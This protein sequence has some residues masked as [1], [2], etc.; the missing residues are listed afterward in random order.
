MKRVLVWVLVCTLAAALC[1]LMPAAS[2]SSVQ[3]ASLVSQSNAVDGMMRISLSS[4]QSNSYNLTVDGTYTMAGM[5]LSS[6]SR[7]LIELN[8]GTVYATYNGS[9]MSM[10][11]SVSLARQSGGIRIAESS[12]PSNTYPGNLTFMYTGGVPY[13]I[14]TVYMEDYVKG[15]LPYEM[16]NTF[17][18]EALK[19]Q[20]VAARTYAI[21][22][23]KSGGLYDVTDTVNHQVYRGTNSGNGNCIQAVDA[24]KGIV[25]RY[26]GSYVDATYCAS[27]GG[28][29]ELNSNAWGSNLVGYLTMKDDPYDLANPSSITKSYMLYKTPAY[30]TSTTAYSMISAA[31]AAKRGGTA[32]QY[33]INEIVDVSLHSTKFASPSRL[34]TQMRVTVRFNNTVQDSVDIAIFPTVES[35]MGL[36]INSSDNELYTVIK[37]SNGFRISARRYG[38]GVGMSQR[39]A[40]QMANS[41]LTYRHILGFYYTGVQLVEMNFTTNWSV[42]NPSV[43]PLPTLPSGTSTTAKKGRVSLA[44][45]SN[46]LNLRQTP[47]RKSVV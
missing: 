35:A 15:V 13:V 39:G 10:G 19:A 33:A 26:N 42:A 40:Q 44:N 21:R 25:M 43:T 22:N 4:M 37:E 7:V 34:Y 20:A 2:A 23:K 47:D 27:N 6:G 18:L 11:A 1:P 17:P 24:T 3:A 32:A 38:H 31:L 9:R 36:S 41:G 12:A 30:G 46:R 5:T 29:T 14:C 45:T 28:Q 16:D 8:N